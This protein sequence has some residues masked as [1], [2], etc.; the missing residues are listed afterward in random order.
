MAES[1]SPISKASMALSKFVSEKFSSK[2]PWKFYSIEKP[3]LKQRIGAFLRG[4]APK[5]LVGVLAALAL[6]GL[7]GLVLGVFASGLI[8]SE[9]L[10]TAILS[11]AATGTIIGFS[12][13]A[14]DGLKE[15][16]LGRDIGPVEAL[17]KIMKGEGVKFQQKKVRTMSYPVIGKVIWQTNYREPIK[18]RNTKDLELLYNMYYKQ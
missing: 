15:A 8:A 17:T 4:A 18:I 2:Y 12:L 1:E 9:T 7:I 5:A 6:A 13:G 11:S 3:T 10:A 16:N 14:K